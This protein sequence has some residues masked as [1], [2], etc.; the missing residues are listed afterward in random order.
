RSDIFAAARCGDSDKVR[1]GVWEDD[2]DAAGGEVK[3]RHEKFVKVMP[4]DRS[5]T[6]LHI[7]AKKGDANLV[8]WLNAHGADPEERDAKGY[9]AFHIALE[10]GHSLIVK[11][12]MDEYPPK[13]PEH[14]AIYRSPPSTSALKLAVS[15]GEPEVVFLTLDNG[16]A[17]KTGAREAWNALPV[18]K[19]QRQTHGKKPQPTREEDL[20]NLLMGF[21][22]IRLDEI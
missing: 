16:L 20:R 1:K 7:A 21:A 13:E 18:P 9:T 8:E 5:E 2:V 12:F 3:A 11:H 15:S 19:S 4:A 17:T 10:K 22:N 6:L 14:A